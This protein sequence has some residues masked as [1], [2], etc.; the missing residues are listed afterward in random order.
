[1]AHTFIESTLIDVTV[2][3]V[4]L[5]IWTMTF[6]TTVVGTNIQRPAVFHVDVVVVA[7]VGIAEGVGIGR[8]GAGGVEST[9]TS[10]R[11]L[12]M[13]MLLLFDEHLGKNLVLFY[14]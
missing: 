4:Q 2:R 3:V 1:M 14:L 13:L 6:P 12:L 8:D 7:R 11:R 5:S 9:T 10:I